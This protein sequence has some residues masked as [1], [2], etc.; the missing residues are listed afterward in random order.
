MEYNNNILA[1]ELNENQIDIRTM[2][3]IRT[4]LGD[5][6]HN[7]TNNIS[8]IFRDGPVLLPDPV[9]I[10]AGGEYEYN[11]GEIRRTDVAIDLGQEESACK[12]NFA[13]IM[14]DFISAEKIFN[15]QN[16]EYIARFQYLVIQTYTNAIKNYINYLNRRYQKRFNPYEDIFFTY[17]GG[18]TMKILFEKYRGIFEGLNNFDDI[19]SKF[20]R[21][22]SDYSI[23]INP[24]ISDN[25]GQNIYLEVYMD[26]NKISLKCLSFIK[27]FIIEKGNFIVPFNLLND[28]D[29]RKI[30]N[31]MNTKLQEIKNNEEG[32][33]NFCKKI[34]KIHSIIGMSYLD[35]QYLMDGENIPDLTNEMID[36]TIENLDDTDEK[37][38]NFRDN[39]LITTKRRNF[40]L[41]WNLANRDSRTIGT[42][43][44]NVD[45]N[46]N[47]DMYISLNETN[48]YPSGTIGE[49]QFCLQRIKINFI[50]YYKVLNENG[51]YSYGLFNAPSELVDVSIMKRDSVDLQKVYEHLKLEFKTFGYQ[52]MS[53]DLKV[54]YRS[55]STY[56]HISDLCNILFSQFEL[57]WLAK[58]Y[59][60]R[61]VRLLFFV[62]LEIMT[63]YNFYHFNLIT[64]DIQKKIE[65]T[66]SKLDSLKGAQI[67][68]KN[69]EAIIKYINEI[70]ASIKR[71][72]PSFGDETGLYKFISYLALLLEKLDQ[73]NCDNM[74]I[75]F[76]QIREYATVIS[77]HKELIREKITERKM[78]KQL[79]EQRRETES[80]S[81]RHSSRSRDSNLSVSKLGGDKF[82]NKYKKYK[83]KYLKLKKEL[84]F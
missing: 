75:F 13:D 84:G 61:V 79:A 15:D 77:S 10:R 72:N 62:Y 47:H 59:Q 2:G 74:I 51:S 71:S 50:A 49:T 23:F 9:R 44:E 27:N 57:P 58:K 48:E 64:T 60:K 37:F 52:N 76:R 65:S 45:R 19:A 20:K 31:K 4:Y 18:T 54:V 17:K 22:D 33:Y 70:K 28:E 14:T 30:I 73:T 24:N 46:N 78:R 11:E 35:R 29:M 1:I 55:Y 21:S 81:S 43:P 56:G 8:K 41:T 66:I 26:I 5:V 80:I 39:K 63:V 7:D 3:D 36:G 69:K 53:G 38:R 16:M 12:K 42:I 68:Q 40:Y 67:T 34:R 83:L 32:D 82:Y 6:F 25:R